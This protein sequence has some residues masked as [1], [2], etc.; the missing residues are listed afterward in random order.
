[1]QVGKLKRGALLANILPTAGRMRACHDEHPAAESV[2]RDL[3]AIDSW[4]R[5]PD[6][7]PR[8]DLASI[9]WPN[10]GCHLVARVQNRHRLLPL[11]AYEQH[12]LRYR[13]KRESHLRH[14]A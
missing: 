8:I 6:P 11:W 1:V 2:W 12:P 7:L 13:V 3:A 5:A 9:P 4:A 14:W 10:T